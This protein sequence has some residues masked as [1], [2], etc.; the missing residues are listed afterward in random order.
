MN[1]GKAYNKN[2]LD[3]VAKAFEVFRIS[4]GISVQCADAGL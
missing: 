1:V 2:K 3:E 4:N